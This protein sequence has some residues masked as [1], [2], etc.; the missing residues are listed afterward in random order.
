MQFHNKKEQFVIGDTVR[1]KYPL[2]LLINI[3]FK[4]IFTT[5]LYIK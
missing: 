1:F 3:N 5:Y 4:L 2:I